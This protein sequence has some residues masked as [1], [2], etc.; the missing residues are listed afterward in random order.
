MNPG[1]PLDRIKMIQRSLRCFVC[2]LLALLPVVGLPFAIVAIGD[3]LRVNRGK[4][5][6]WNPAARYARTGLVCAVAGLLIEMLL[7][8]IVFIEVS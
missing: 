3:F 1:T 2:G 8:A 4:D 5:A 6:T 7:A